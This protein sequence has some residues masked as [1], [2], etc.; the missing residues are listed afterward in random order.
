MHTAHLL[1]IS[2]SFPCISGE[3]DLPN[4]PGCRPPP[5]Q[6]C[7]LGCMLGSQPHPMDRRNGTHA[8]TL[9]QTLFAGGNNDH[10][11]FE[12]LAIPRTKFVMAKRHWK[13]KVE[14][15]GFVFPVRENS[16]RPKWHIAT[17]LTAKGQNLQ[18]G[19]QMTV[20]RAITKLQFCFHAEVSRE[21]LNDIRDLEFN[22]RTNET[23]SVIKSCCVV[24]AAVLSL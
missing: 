4:P 16:G 11:N 22:Q 18:Q 6:S 9:P 14:K 24:W 13:T 15:M 3:G 2:R 19:R 1:T 23:S 7:D 8:I 17:L 21:L 12:I 20:C 10:T 5:P